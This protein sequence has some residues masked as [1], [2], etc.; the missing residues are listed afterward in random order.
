MRCKN[1]FPSPSHAIIHTAAHWKHSRKHL[2]FV[3]D[4]NNFK[5]GK[6]RVQQLNTWEQSRLARIASK[7]RSHEECHHH[8]FYSSY[9]FLAHYIISWESWHFGGAFCW[10]TR[11]W[12]NRRFFKTELRKR[13]KSE[14]SNYLC[15]TRR[16]GELMRGGT[17]R[18][19]NF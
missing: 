15:E 14:N 13:E 12:K 11:M 16:M 7:P 17:L 6:F 4:N 2:F 5:R 10:K 8:Q 18:Y 9:I 1:S 19:F 3:R